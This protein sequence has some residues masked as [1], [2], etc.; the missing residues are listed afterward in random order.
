MAQALQGGEIPC[1]PRLGHVGGRVAPCCRRLVKEGFVQCR[2]EHERPAPKL[3]H[4]GRLLHP[5]RL[6]VSQGAFD[7]GYGIQG[8][9]ALSGKRSSKALGSGKEKDRIKVVALFISAISPAISES[10]LYP[11]LSSP[12]GNRPAKARPRR[13]SRR[14]SRAS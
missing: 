5:A 9:E 14:T 1:P 3:L 7:E 11:P 13:P 2:D 6:V 8:G 12:S 10:L 4:R